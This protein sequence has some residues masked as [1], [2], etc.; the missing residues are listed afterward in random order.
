[1]CT[2]AI[3]SL[4]LPTHQHPLCMLSLHKAPNVQ[5]ACILMMFH[6]VGL[7]AFIHLGFSQDMLPRSETLILGESTTI[8]LDNN[9]AT[10]GHAIMW[11]N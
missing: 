9:T 2:Y 5:H 8:R 7:H 6:N 10:D 1:M 3:A 4:H 11:L